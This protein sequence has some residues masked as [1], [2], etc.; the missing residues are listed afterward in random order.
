MRVNLGMKADRIGEDNIVFIFLSIF[1]VGCGAEQITRM[2]FWRWIF[3]M[4]E[5]VWSRTGVRTDAD[6]YSQIVH[7]YIYLFIPL[8][9]S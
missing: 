2:R 1:F 9:I 5:M 6:Y 3:Q 8:N 7:S 4:L